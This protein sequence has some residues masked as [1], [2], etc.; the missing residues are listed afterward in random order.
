MSGGENKNWETRH[1]RLPP[2][3]ASGM[4]PS[5]FCLFLGGRVQV[6]VDVGWPT[7][8]I[9]AELLRVAPHFQQSQIIM[10]IFSEPQVMFLQT[11][12]F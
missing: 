2:V 3:M 7:F 1:A 5:N 10:R 9:S 12:R 8:Y 11:N 4:H 6:D